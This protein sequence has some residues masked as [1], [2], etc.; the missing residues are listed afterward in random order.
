M[1]PW[2]G[3]YYLPCLL[4]PELQSGQPEPGIWR[5]R[6]WTS[7]FR[8]LQQ[9]C[10]DS[11]QDAPQSSRMSCQCTKGHIQVCPAVFQS[12]SEKSNSYSIL[13]K[14]DDAL[15]SFSLS[16]SVALVLDEENIPA[17]ILILL[18]YNG[19]QVVPII[20]L[21]KLSHKVLTRLKHLTC[22]I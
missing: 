20:G 19:K 22:K 21:C 17:T 6:C 11:V 14:T 2:L 1:K 12:T 7:R 15:G 9:S 8:W 16:G 18:A 3:F 5:T 4:C 13:I 10:S